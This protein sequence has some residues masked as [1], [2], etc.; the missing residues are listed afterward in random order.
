M[1]TRVGASHVVSS[2]ATVFGGETLS[3]NHLLRHGRDES[4]GGTRVDFALREAFS[5]TSGRRLLC[6]SCTSPVTSE[7]ARIAIDGSHVHRRTNPS[8]IEF[9]FGCFATAPGVHTLGTP[10]AEFS[11]FPGYTWVYAVCRECVT[12]LGWFFS[13]LSPS[14]HGL[15][16]A[17]LMPEGPG[18]D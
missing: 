6:R 10:T 13:G 11:W 9:E 7:T 4:Q 18:P 16:L 5:E 14:F 3:V 1:A 12:H 17:R 2:P 8:G 15:I